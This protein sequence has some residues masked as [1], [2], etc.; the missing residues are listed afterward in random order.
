[1]FEYDGDMLCSDCLF[2]NFEHIDSNV[3]TKCDDCGG[4]IYG[5]EVAIIGDLK[6]CKYCL[7]KNL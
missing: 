3:E 4:G 5:D 1:M 6:L 7:T 2:D